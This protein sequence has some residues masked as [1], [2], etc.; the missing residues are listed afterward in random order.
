MGIGYIAGNGSGGGV[1]SDEVTAKKENV[2][3]GKTTVTADSDN[4][5]VGGSMKNNGSVK[6]TLAINGSYTIPKGYH[7]GTGKVTQS[8]QTRNGDTFYPA[9]YNMTV[10]KNQYLTGDLIVHAITQSGL[11]TGNILRGQTITI[12]NGKQDVWKVTGANYVMR[13]HN[14]AEKGNGTNKAFLM[15]HVGQTDTWNYRMYYMDISPGFTPV[16]VLCLGG[17]FMMWRY[18]NMMNMVS[19]SNAIGGQ[20]DG[21]IEFVNSSDAPF[22]SNQLRI[23]YGKY[24]SSAQYNVWVTVIGY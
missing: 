21:Y 9:G 11:Y 19:N 3:E 22:K 8:I 15:R 1:T 23:F 10:S 17:G 2:L 20:R 6:H 16:Y 7:D 5:V 4:A 12:N 18:G 13:V 24:D 14:Y